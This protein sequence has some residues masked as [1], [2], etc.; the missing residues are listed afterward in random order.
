M[1]FKNTWDKTHHRDNN[2]EWLASGYPSMGAFF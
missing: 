2:M 1:H